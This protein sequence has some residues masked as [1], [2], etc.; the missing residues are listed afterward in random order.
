MFLATGTGLTGPLV[1][2]FRMQSRSWRHK[3]S[4]RNLLPFEPG[5]RRKNSFSPEKKLAFGMPQRHNVASS[6]KPTG[7]AITH[8]EFPPRF[9][10]LPARPREAGLAGPLNHTV[11]SPNDWPNVAAAAWSA[12]A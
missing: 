1:P 11:G 10:R 5:F 9:R 3:L 6:R 12:T 4:Q 7:D 2:L 8:P